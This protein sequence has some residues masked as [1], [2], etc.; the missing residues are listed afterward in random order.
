MTATIDPTST[1]Y[2]GTDPVELTLDGNTL[3]DMFERVVKAV[4]KLTKTSYHYATTPCFQVAYANGQLTLTFTDTISAVRYTKDIDPP[5]AAGTAFEVNVTPE[6]LYWL[7][8]K[9]KSFRHVPTI[10]ATYNGHDGTLTLNGDS[11]S[12]TVTPFAEKF[13]GSQALDR[14]MSYEP[15][16]TDHRI[17]VDPRRMVSALNAATEKGRTSVPATMVPVGEGWAKTGSGPV[18]VESDGVP[19]LVIVLMSMRKPSS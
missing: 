10:Q 13:S 9:V 2:T 1:N 11:A 12:V 15:V 7:A 18:R 19:G 4:P 6:T 14:I 3:F 5:A 17:S 16:D 8:D